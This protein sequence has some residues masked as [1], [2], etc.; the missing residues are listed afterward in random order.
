MF[1]VRGAGKQAAGQELER[2]LKQPQSEGAGPG[3]DPPHGGSGGGGGRGPGQHRRNRLILV[4]GLAIAVVIAGT[5]FVV[6]RSGSGSNYTGPDL[7]L[8]DVSVLRLAGVTPATDSTGVNGAA[9]VI[10]QFNGPLKDGSPNP[11]ISPAVAGTW[12]HSGDSAVFAPATALAPSTRYTVSVPAG[13]RARGGARLAG[14]T[15]THFTTGAYSQLRLGQL[16]SQL[17]YLPLT[18][19]PA[20]SPATRAEALNGGGVAQSEA[21]MAFNPPAGTFTFQSGYPA[22]LA[23]MW[24]PNQANVL[25]RGAVMAFQHDHGML[26]TA[27][28][29]PKLWAAL[30]KAASDGSRNASG[31]SYA[32]ASKTL[33]ESLTIWHN[34]HEVF[35]SLA[36]TGIPVSPTANGTFPVYQKYTFQIMRGVNPDGSS[37]ADPVSFVSYFNGGDAVHYF[38]R[39]GYGYQQSLGCVELPYNAAEAAYP[40]LTYGT[41]VTVAN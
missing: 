23:A 9:P 41:L 18:W 6:L 36:N 13:I 38:P 7:T 19:T 20:S 29:G 16:L 3:G 15:T 28:V 32:L 26:P 35:H 8:P 21:A 30:F 25:L 11:V 1:G 33:P 39:P 4:G 2:P 37:Y 24:N 27:D 10:V 40:F 22:G 5:T 14:T 12:T 17:G 31:Y 34:G